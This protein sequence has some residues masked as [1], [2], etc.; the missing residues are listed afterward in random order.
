M[1]QPPRRRRMSAKNRRRRLR[2]LG[3]LLVLVA[4]LAGSAYVALQASGGDLLAGD[5]RGEEGAARETPS[6]SG[7]ENDQGE[8]G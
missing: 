6:R 4:L 5:A 8:N 2:R 1:D 7:D 3:A